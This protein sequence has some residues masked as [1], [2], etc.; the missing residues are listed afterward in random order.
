[1]SNAQKKCSYFRVAELHKSGYI[2]YHVCVNQFLP[3]KIIRNLWQQAVAYALG[4]YP[5]KAFAN[6]NIKQI[7][8][9]KTA[10]KYCAKYLKK[11]IAE[12]EYNDI[13]RTSKSRDIP[14]FFPKKI[15]VAEYICLTEKEAFMYALYIRNMKEKAF[16]NLEHVKN[17]ATNLTRENSYM[18][19]ELSEYYA[20]C[21]D[22][23]DFTRYLE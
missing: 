12:Q 20:D 15:T 4:Y 16:A 19:F 10:A 9:A 8:D 14:A 1:M 3:V 13:L 11:G 2:H 7:S 22:D 5:S 17:D 23:V 21:P 6:V 18:P